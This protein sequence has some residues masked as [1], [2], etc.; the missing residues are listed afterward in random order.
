VSDSPAIAAYH[1][2]FKQRLQFHMLREANQRLPEVAATNGGL[3]DQDVYD[4]LALA[5]FEAVGTMMR[6]Q[7][8]RHTAEM[9]NQDTRHAAE[10]Q[11]QATRL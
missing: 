9:E 10:L 11:D 7:A 3:Q 5:S 6:D 4:S 1:V 8:A 2:D